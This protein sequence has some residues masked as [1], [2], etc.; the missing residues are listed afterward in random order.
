MGPA[1]AHLVALAD[2]MAGRRRDRFTGLGRGASEAGANRAGL[3]SAVEV[4]RSLA[5]VPPRCGPPRGKS[6]AAGKRPAQPAKE[7]GSWI[8]ECW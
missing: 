4:G 3:P 6:R 5:A 2:A 8:S 1:P 7:E